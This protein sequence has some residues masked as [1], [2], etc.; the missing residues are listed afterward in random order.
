[1]LLAAGC[2]RKEKR[3]N[4]RVLR[5]LVAAAAVAAAGPGYT[6]GEPSACDVQAAGR[7]PME[8]REATLA[9]YER[10]PRACLQ[11][12]FRACSQAADR[13]LLDLGSAATCSIGYE[14]LL[15][16]HFG[17]SFSALLAWWQTQRTG[18]TLQ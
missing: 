5:C 9:R 13:S 6:E 15:R 18:T 12:I 11:Q 10:L 2:R 14:A 7:D 4:A 1:M 17:G 8:D 3:M 16:Q